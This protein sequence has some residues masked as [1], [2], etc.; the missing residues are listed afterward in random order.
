[1]TFDILIKNGTVFDGVANEGYLADIGIVEN[2][3]E[4]IGKLSSAKAKQ[5]IDASNRYVCPGFIDIQN[6]SDSYLTLFEYPLQES[7]VTQG[8]TTILLGHCGASLA[9]LSGPEAFKSVQKWRSVM[10]A[11]LNWLSFE[12]Y[13]KALEDYWFGV[14][15]ASLV[16]HSTVRRGLLGDE[17]RPATAE[18]IKISA[19]LY[20]ESLEAGAGGMSL[21]LI[22]AHEIDASKAELEQAAKIVA[23]KNKLL[24]VH[25][26]SEG[27]QVVSALNEVIA[28]AE[29]SGA[30]LKI[31]HLKIRGEENWQF[32]EEALAIIDRAYQ[33]GVEV[34]FDI[35][36]YV[37]SWTVLY[38]YLPKWAYRGGRGAILQNLKNPSIREKVLGYLKSHRHNLGNIMI[39]TSQTNPAFLGKT[40][41]QIAA[42]QEISVEEA[43]LNVITGTEAQVVVFDYNLSPCD[44]D[45]LL[46]HPLSVV[47]SDGA[48]YDFVDS[49]NHGLIHPRCFGTMPKFLSMVREKGLL[50]WAQ[51]IKKITGYP[52]EKLGLSKRGRLKEGYFADLVVFD[53]NEIGS[54]ASY[55]HPFLPAD[56]IDLVLVNGRA[57][58]EKNME[59]A[60]E[61]AGKVLRL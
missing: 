43:L 46:K 19:K 3:I 35:Y 27:G 23:Q 8:I 1:M 18:E 38:T 48:G 13:L 51:A 22:Y 32:L 24:S 15:V 47:G 44:L 41:A 21:G 10:G 31:S 30:R 12:E 20:Q 2:K 29:S 59:G 49:V 11:N 5:V 17:V 25:L 9:P 42:N 34:F 7:L 56:G 58:F 37:S 50:S 45:K 54:R 28:L 39:A 16:G 26:R 57:A 33:R 60:R 4:A 40:L 52:A 6:H 36:P 55:E 14:N 53:P 61:S